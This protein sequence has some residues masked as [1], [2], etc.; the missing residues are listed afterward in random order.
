MKERSFF[1]SQ[2]CNG[3]EKCRQC[4]RSRDY[5]RGIVAAFDKPDD[6]DFECPFGKT[7]DDFPLEVEPG[8]FEMAASFGNSVS[9][10]VK[11]WIRRTPEK[12]SREETERRMEVCGDCEFMRGS[13]CVKCGCFLRFKTRFAGDGCPIG[14][15]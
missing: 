6:Y 2:L 8:I 7:V 4:R 3:F 10:E 13:R 12:V 1:K 14:K 9:K 11:G 15:W 5:R